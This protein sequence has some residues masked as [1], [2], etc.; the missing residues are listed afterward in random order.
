MQLNPTA[1][2]FIGRMSESE[3]ISVRHANDDRL[4]YLR[5]TSFI[6]DRLSETEM[7][8][9]RGILHADFVK[10]SEGLE[11]GRTWTH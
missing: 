9:A 4:E 1:E 6:V 8:R 2:R 11:F 7:K 10:A 5:Q 3:K